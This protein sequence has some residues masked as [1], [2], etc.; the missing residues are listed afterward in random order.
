MSGTLYVVAT[1]IGNLGDIT[2]RALSTLSDADFIAAED[3]RVTRKL[4]SHF[5]IK[6][7]MVSYHEHNKA[8]SGPRI[9]ER[10]LGGENCA[11][12][13]DAGSPVISDP[14]QELVALAA[15]AGVAVTALPGPC[16]AI[17]ALCLAGLDCGR[18]SFEGFLPRDKKA[19][20]AALEIAKSYQGALV[21]YEAPHRVRQT[22]AELCTALGDRTLVM[23]RELTKLHEEV[24]RGSLSDAVLLLQTQEPRGEYVLVVD[25]PETVQAEAAD[26]QKALEMA[27]KLIAEGCSASEA[28][29]Q[30]A[31]QT[32]CSK[33]DIYPLL[34]KNKS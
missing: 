6:T 29:K 26:P 19:R 5:E 18:F 15:K 22:L 12:V 24:W 20:R 28:A 11:L 34:I 8:E 16:A 27:L 14:G 30:V 1:P 23:A 7:P 13:T 9:V 17:T 3:T 25:Q 10:L 33:S 2:P 21:Y 31:R 32:G 4:L